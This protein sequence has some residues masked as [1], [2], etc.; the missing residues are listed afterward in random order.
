[1]YEIMRKPKDKVSDK[2]RVS[3]DVACIGI[4]IYCHGRVTVI[5]TFFCFLQVGWMM[6]NWLVSVLAV[7]SGIV[8]YDGSPLVPHGNILWDLV[9]S[10][11]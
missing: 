5:F 3:H 1:M 2:D 4:K 7:G 11:G 9:D 8:L 6:W 10:I